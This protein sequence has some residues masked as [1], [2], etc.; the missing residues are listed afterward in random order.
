MPTGYHQIGL[1]IA[2]V[3]FLQRLALPLVSFGTLYASVYLLGVELN[4]DQSPQ[5]FALALIASLLSYI[6]VSAQTKKTHTQGAV[7]SAWTATERI[8]FSWCAV[9]AILLFIGYMGKV[10]AV[11]SRRVLITWF[12]VTP[13]IALALWVLLRAWL[14]RALLK[15]G[16]SRTAVI[17]GVNAASRKLAT[18]LDRHPEFGLN[19]K[20]Y[21][22]DRSEDRIGESV[23]DSLLG[24]LADLPRLARDLHFDI[25]FVA[26]PIG[27]VTRT[28]QLLDELKDTTASIYFVPDLLVVD[29]IQSRSDEIA[30][31]PVL[32]LCESPFHG[33][34]G[35]LKRIFDLVVASTMLLVAG[36]LMLAIA[37]AIKFTTP[38]NV[39]FRQRRYGLRGEEIVVYKFRTMTSSDDGQ[40]VKQA[41]SDDSRVTPVGRFLRRYSLDELPQ[42]INVL[43]GRM[44]IV[45]PRPHAVAHNETY[46]KLIKGY[47]VRH[48]VA[49][50]ITGL[51]QVNGCRGETAKIEDMEMRVMYDLRYLREW[52]LFLDF[53]IL[54]QTARSLLS[55]ENAY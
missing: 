48:K 17:A 7:T 27:H 31:V 47:M 2:T 5:Y 55:D 4:D 10:S 1:G 15:S 13:P 42:L 33:Y 40:Q 14:R 19:F 16:I 41:T 21:F 36:P 43:Q 51:A 37:A 25:I 50:G 24:K 11:F 49:P 29:L 3:T 6:F 20:G 23:G 8:V 26:I 18:I 12:V 28:H 39:I 35:V 38:G 52:T 53:K 22:E 54:I 32:A 44:S 34:H 45:G 9:I 46:R 30:G